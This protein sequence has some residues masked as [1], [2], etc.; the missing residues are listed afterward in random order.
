MNIVSPITS[1]EEVEPVVDAGTNEIYCGVL[2]K[3]E[4]RNY[5]NLGCL[6]RRPLK[7]A[8]LKSFQELKKTVK[9]AHSHNI[10]V[11]FTINNFYT[12]EQYSLASEQIE[13]DIDS[14]VDALMVADI[15]LFS[16]FEEKGCH[17]PKIHVSTLGTT[18]NSQA[19]RFYQELG[20]QRVILP[21]HLALEEI[22][23]IARTPSP[24]EVEVFILNEQ[25]R[26]VDGLCNFQHGL[27]EL[28]GLLSLGF[29]STKAGRRLRGLLPDKISEIV[30]NL[31]CKD[32]LGC[33][34]NYNISIG[35]DI[36]DTEK[37]NVSKAF[38]YFF[39]I[40]SFSKAC[41]ACAIYDL[42]RLGV[43]FVKIVGRQASLKK[44]ARDVRFIRKS[45]GLLGEKLTKQG[46]QEKVR[47]LYQRIYHFSCNQQYCYYRGS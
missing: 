38:S 12:A 42:N 15:G 45:L 29:E 19:L 24:V 30:R 4:E 43:G 36:S 33:S 6:N 21:R 11:T 44:K 7:F 20:A 32:E 23:M 16:S 37:K 8:N 22:G 47:E 17:I 5:T 27:L 34:L 13:K 35:D 2:T 1:V 3:K 9:L 28:R 14:G 10:S 25:C 41:G 18:F 39:D 40:E 26:Y 31:L 46:F